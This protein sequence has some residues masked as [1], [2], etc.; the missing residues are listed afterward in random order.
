VASGGWVN[1]QQSAP[2]QISIQ[3]LNYS[4]V[5]ADP[6]VSLTVQ[7][8]PRLG[9]LELYG[10][11]VYPGQEMGASDIL[12]GNF[13]YVPSGDV[14]AAYSTSFSFSVSDGWQSSTH[15]AALGFQVEVTPNSPPAITGSS[16][17]LNSPQPAHRQSRSRISDTAILTMTPCNQSRFPTLRLMDSL[18]TMAIRFTVASG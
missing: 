3:D 1:L 11:P 17:S 6:I 14:A 4:D 7:T 10:F 16:H 2:Y 5:D 13:N 8:L 15:S 9:A 12:F 18:S